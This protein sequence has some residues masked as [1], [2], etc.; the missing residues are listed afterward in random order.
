MEEYERLKIE[1]LKAQ[2]KCDK[3]FACVKS[4]FKELCSAQYNCDLR[5]FIAQNLDK[6]IAKS[7][8]F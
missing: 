8:A 5:I 4:K 3:N 7:A 1:E 6:W 2:V